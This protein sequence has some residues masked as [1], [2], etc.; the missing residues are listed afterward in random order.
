M[1][2]RALFL[3]TLLLLSL[4]AMLLLRRCVVGVLW[5]KITKL[6]DLTLPTFT[7]VCPKESDNSWTEVLLHCVRAFGVCFPSGG[8]ACKVFVC[9]LMF[10]YACVGCAIVFCLK[11]NW[12]ACQSSQSN[13]CFAFWKLFW[14]SSR[15]SPCFYVSAWMYML[16]FVIPYILSCLTAFLVLCICSTN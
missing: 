7:S 13:L 2:C 10:L 8:V 5:L 14:C 16:S 3:T 1:W 11:V 6:M 4:C 9:F 12:S 15:V